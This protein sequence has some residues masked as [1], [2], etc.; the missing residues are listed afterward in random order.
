MP[1]QNIGTRLTMW[2]N[3]YDLNEQEWLEFLDKYCTNPKHLPRVFNDSVEDALEII[4][5]KLKFH[6]RR[7][8]GMCTLCN[9][10]IHKGSLVV[11]WGEWKG[12]FAVLHPDCWDVVSWELQNRKKP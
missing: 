8:D 6:R 5:D 4:P 2:G 10:T 11:S 3:S 1:T 9:K 7:A 12:V